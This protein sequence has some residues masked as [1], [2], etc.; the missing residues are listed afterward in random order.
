MTLIEDSKIFVIQM[1]T[2][3]LRLDELM[4]I[5]PVAT[6]LHPWNR[7]IVLSSTTSLVISRPSHSEEG[8]DGS[9]YHKTNSLVRAPHSRMPLSPVGHCPSQGIHCPPLEKWFAGQ[10]SRQLPLSS[11]RPTEGVR[12]RGRE[13]KEKERRIR[14]NKKR[15]VESW[16]EVKGAIHFKDTRQKTLPYQGRSQLF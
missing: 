2:T 9:H 15:G 11:N 16:K 13:G 6:M 5:L 12:R 10:Q 3:Y 14:G 7:S 1:L 8:K 4:M